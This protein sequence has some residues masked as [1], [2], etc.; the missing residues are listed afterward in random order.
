MHRH[1]LFLAAAVLSGQPIYGSDWQQITPDLNLPTISEGPPAAGKRVRQTTAGW[2][3]TQVHHLLY[4]P[5]DWK[6]DTKLPVLIE[7]AGN[8]PFSNKLGDTCD[9]SVESCL[10]GYGISAGKGFIWASLPFI[11]TADGTQR[12]ATKW[13]EDVEASKRYTLKTVQDLCSRFGGDPDRVILCG[14][15]R[16]S[17]G[18]HFIGLH[19]DEIAKLWRGFVCHSHYDGVRAWPYA[20]ADQKSA[21]ARLNRLGSRPEWISHEL[22][23]AATEAWLTSTGIQGNWTFTSMPFP[24]HT[25]AWV[26]RD[27]P[28]RQKLRDWVQNVCR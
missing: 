24:N 6:P 17:I 28:E 14:F 23:T 12:N 22:S 7:Y 20:G 9:G 5:T 11:E 26:L 19:D 2:E 13:W 10:L 1:L 21:I 18:C 25:T 15:S 3:T 8:G 4:L 16:G 27:L